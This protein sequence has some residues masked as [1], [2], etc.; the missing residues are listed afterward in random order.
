MANY[1]L[2]TD[3]GSTCPRRADVVP[4]PGM[5]GSGPDRLVSGKGENRPN[6]PGRNDFW[7]RERL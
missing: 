6:C 4:L 7:H 5:T 2:T 3:A 1:P